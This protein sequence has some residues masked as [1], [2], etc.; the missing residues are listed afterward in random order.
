MLSFNK[1]IRVLLPLIIREPV[2][3]INNDDAQYKAIRAYQN[4][5]MREKDT[6]RDLLAFPVGSTVTMHHE[7]GVPWMHGFIK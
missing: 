1:P 3:I 4:R 6:H 2:S 5:Y 7:D